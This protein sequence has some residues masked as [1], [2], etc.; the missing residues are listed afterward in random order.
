MEPKKG[1][2]M[3][4]HII[5]MEAAM[6]SWKVEAPRL[7]R[8]KGIIVDMEINAMEGVNTTPSIKKRNKLCFTSFS[9]P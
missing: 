7:F 2:I 3:K 4:V 1:C 8:K 6:A 5:A 9:L